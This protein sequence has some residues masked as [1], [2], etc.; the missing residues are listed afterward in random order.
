MNRTRAVEEEVAAVAA[1][2]TTLITLYQI[3]IW[4]LSTDFIKLTYNTNTSSHGFRWKVSP[5]LGP[6]CSTVSM[7]T[8]DLAPNHT[9]FAGQRVSRA[10]GFPT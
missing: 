2:I 10:C 7:W 6:D 4:L 1:A 8:C 9:D 3:I 5:E